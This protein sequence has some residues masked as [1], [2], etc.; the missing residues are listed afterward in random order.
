MRS[1]G[2]TFL[3]GLEAFIEVRARELDGVEESDPV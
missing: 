3:I 2:C 1:A